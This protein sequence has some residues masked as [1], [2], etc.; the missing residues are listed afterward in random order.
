[1]KQVHK[2]MMLHQTSD[3]TKHIEDISLLKCVMIILVVAFH[4]VYIGDS[5]PYAKRFVYAFHMPV[6]LMLS[7]YFMKPD[8]QVSK[9]GRRVLFYAIPYFVMEA[10]YVIMASLLPIREHIDGLSVPLFLDKLLL[11]PLGPYWYLHTL[12]LCSVASFSVLHAKQL[13][14]YSRIVALGIVLYLFSRSGVVSFSMA[15]YYLMGVIIRYSRTDILKLF[16]P[17]VLSV[18]ALF[19]LALYPG[20][21][22]SDSIGALLIVCMSVS[23]CL[24]V[25]PY[26]K[27][28][29]RRCMLFL[30][31]NTLPIYLF[32]PLFT[33]LCKGLVHPLAF[34]PSRMLFLA[35]SL[36][37]C[38][39]GSLAI[40]LAMD[41]CGVSKLFFGRDRSLR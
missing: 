17:S 38:I 30:G 3:S 13:G 28:K 39:S 14:T 23:S 32:S 27:G 8:E 7:G 31:R 12:V 4:L 36:V 16:R 24:T 22:E 41:K 33:I 2:P 10:G 37:I 26:I 19:L 25:F 40:S 6:F 35:V 9:F 18:F 34:D 21:L 29:M 1:M 11:H 20:N 5:F 15:C